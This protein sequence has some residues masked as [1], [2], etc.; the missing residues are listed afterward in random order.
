MDTSTWKTS[1][2]GQEKTEIAIAFS[3]EPMYNENWCLDSGATSHMCRDETKFVNM[4]PVMNEE[5]RLA[6]NKTTKIK[7]RGT[8][9]LNVKNGAESKTLNLE[10]TLCVPELKTNLLSISKS[11]LNGRSV[12]FTESHAEIANPDGLVI[13]TAVREG[14]LY[15]VKPSDAPDKDRKTNY[16]KTWHE[17]Y[18]HL[19]E[20]ELKNLVAKDLVKGVTFNVSDEFPV[21]ESCARG[22]IPPTPFPEGAKRS[23]EPLG[24]VHTDVRGPMRTA[25]LGGAKYFVTFVDDRSRWVEV[26]FA[27]GRGEVRGAFFKYRER[28]EEEKGAMVG[29]LRT[30]L[31][32]EF[33]GLGFDEELRGVGV[34]RVRTAMMTPKAAPIAR[35]M[36]RTL[37]HMAKYMLA[38]ANLPQTFWAEAVGRLGLGHPCGSHKFEMNVSLGCDRGLHPKPI[39]DEE[40]GGW[41]TLHLLVRLATGGL[42]PAHLWVQGLRAQQ[43]RGQER[44]VHFHGLRR[45]LKGLQAVGPAE[46]EDYLLQ[47]GQV[48][49]DLAAEDEGPAHVKVRMIFS[50]KNAKSLGRDTSCRSSGRDSP[51]DHRNHPHDDLEHGLEKV[52]DRLAL[53]AQ[54]AQERAEHQAEEDDPQSVGAAPVLDDPYQL[55]ALEH[56]LALRQVADPRSFGDVH[57]MRLKIE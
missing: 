5:V 10:N 22:G 45:G 33:L 32:M 48:R 50:F 24:V 52:Q 57:C 31:G 51:H 19:N 47:G 18:C 43:V 11:T 16:L 41:H 36:N 42:P 38:Q 4:I 29:V 14:D 49:G 20:S 28:C 46:E 55:L 39:P 17:R 27:K 8:V 25:S 26:H 30:D 21:C 2:N 7:G 34:E 44:G 56:F 23:E 6:V 53:F 37:V 15:F 54:R 12:R 40:P 1:P 3:A 35:R 9:R 13:L